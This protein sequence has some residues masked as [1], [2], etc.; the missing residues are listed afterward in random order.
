M[1]K[2]ITTTIPPTEYNKEQGWKSNT[3][4]CMDVKTFLRSD[5]MTKPGKDYHGILRRDVECEEFRYEEHYTF[6]ELS[7]GSAQKRN[8]RVYDG[9]RITI[10]QGDDGQLRPN[11]KHLPQLDADITIDDY[12]FEVMSEL[13]QAL[14]GLVG[15]V[16]K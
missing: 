12:A 7:E 9:R 10:T 5:N 6:I 14:K 13:R 15:Q 1:S 11:F 4:I 16:D 3:D 8:P 2:K